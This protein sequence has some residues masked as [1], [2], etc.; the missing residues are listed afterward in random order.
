MF[1]NLRKYT[2]H[3]IVTNVAISS[4]VED[5]TLQN[6]DLSQA[7]WEDLELYLEKKYGST[8]STKIEPTEEDMNLLIDFISR[9]E[10]EED[11][12]LAQA[13]LAKFVKYNDSHPSLTRKS[14]RASKLIQK[15]KFEKDSS[16]EASVENFD[17]Q[18]ESNE[19]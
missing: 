14:A 11:E 10:F 8:K 13:W 2:L 9:A 12:E 18:S 7:P 1:S 16:N 17:S 3:L 5:V 6:I 19:E 4:S 15:S